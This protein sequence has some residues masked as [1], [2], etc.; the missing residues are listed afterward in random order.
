[1]PHGKWVRASGFLLETHWG[2]ERV[3][4]KALTLVMGLAEW[5]DS[6]W[7]AATALRLAT[8]WA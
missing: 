7:E 8:T 4:V 1:L 2:L 3:K 5:L 6:P